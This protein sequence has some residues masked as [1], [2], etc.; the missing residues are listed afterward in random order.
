MK[1]IKGYVKKQLWKGGTQYKAESNKTT[2]ATV[3]DH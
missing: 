2:A 1:K 3:L